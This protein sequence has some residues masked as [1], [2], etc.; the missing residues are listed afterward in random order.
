MKKQKGFLIVEALSATAV[1]AFLLLGSTYVISN[2]LMNSAVSDKKIMLTDEL[3]TRI[4]LFAL[5][6]K[7]DSKVDG[8]M[9]FEQEETGNKLLKF[10]G[11]NKD[12]NIKISKYSFSFVDSEN[13]VICHKPG[14]NSQKTK[15]VPETALIGH[16]R[17]GDTFGACVDTKTNNGHVN[18][19]DGVDSSNPGNSKDGED[20]N[21]NVDDEADTG[22][23]SNTTVETVTETTETTETVVDTSPGNSGK[24]NG[25][26][27]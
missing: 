24:S 3:D 4:N 8:D 20:T 14:E 5:T 16:L 12:Y 1:V 17:H 13:I 23:N 19:L 22:V 10:V 15:T 9:T 21:L 26:K 2:I 27:K 25:K 7:F 11:E 18:N 6:G